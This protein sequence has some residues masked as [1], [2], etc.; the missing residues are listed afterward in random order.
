MAQAQRTARVLVDPVSGARGTIRDTRAD[1][2]YRIAAARTG[3]LAWA[4]SIVEEALHA[5]AADFL[6]RID[7]LCGDPRTYPGQLKAGSKSPAERK[8]MGV[9]SS[10]DAAT[11]FSGRKEG[12][13]GGPVDLRKSGKRPR[14]LTQETT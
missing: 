6:M 9:P 4:R 13:G 2:V 5:Y 3:G 7:E 1:G 14:S 10:Q 8:P 11:S 12:R